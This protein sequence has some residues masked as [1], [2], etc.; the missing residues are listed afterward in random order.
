MLMIR[1][2]GRGPHDFL[3]KTRVALYNR[4]GEEIVDKPDLLTKKVNEVK[5]KHFKFVI[6][7]EGD[8]VISQ[9]PHENERLQEGK[10]VILF[11]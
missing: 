1:T 9:L 3:A 8:K 4:N 6:I 10:E 11:T 2:D 7:G 5:S